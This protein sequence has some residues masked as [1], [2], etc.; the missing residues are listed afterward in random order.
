MQNRYLR[1]INLPSATNG[2]TY[3]SQLLPELHNRVKEGLGNLLYC[4]ERTELAV[5]EST[6]FD[7]ATLQ[8]RDL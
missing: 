4:V 8:Q 2:G 3:T 7:T 5:S 1:R 6:S